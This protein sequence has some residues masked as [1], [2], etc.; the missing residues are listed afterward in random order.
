M[1]SHKCYAV[2]GVKHLEAQEKS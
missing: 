1:K 2:L